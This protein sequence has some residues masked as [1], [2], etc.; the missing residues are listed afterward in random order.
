MYTYPG[1]QQEFQTRRLIPVCVCTVVGKWFIHSQGLPN[2]TFPIGKIF[3]GY[4]LSAPHGSIY[5]TARTGPCPAS[6]TKCFSVWFGTQLGRHH[7][8]ERSCLILYT[9]GKEG[10]YCNRA[11]NNLWDEMCS[12]GKKKQEATARAKD[13]QIYKSHLWLAITLR[14]LRNF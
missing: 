4:L 14:R 6:N 3:M 11:W 8:N 2:T 10:I 5:A 7:E 12:G 1:A 13:L 9:R